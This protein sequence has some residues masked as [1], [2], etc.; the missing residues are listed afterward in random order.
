[1]LPE[2]FTDRMRRMLGDEYEEFIKAFEGERHQ[3]LRLNALKPGMGGKTGAEAPAGLEGN[4]SPGNE[5]VAAAEKE[6]VGLER[7]SPV[8]W[9]EN[10]YYYEPGLQPGK[11]PFHEAGVYYIQEPSAM[12][13][14]ELLEVKPG[15]R[16][17]DLCAAPGGKSTQM[18]AKL[19]G[20]GILVCNEI[21]PARAKILSE[22]VERMGIGNACVTNETPERLAAA[23]PEYFDRILVDAPCSGEGMFRKNPAACEEWSPENVRLCAVRQ[24]EILDCGAQMLRPGGRLVYS[25][26]TFAEEEDEGS[27]E[28]FLG[29]HPDFRLVPVESEKAGLENCSGQLAGTIRLM[30]HKVR[31]EGHFAAVL[32]RVCEDSGLRSC[33]GRREG[34]REGKCSGSL[35]Y[36]GFQRAP[37]KELGDYL[38][39]CRENLRQ[40][41]GAGLKEPGRREKAAERTG[42]CFDA[43][44]ERMHSDSGK[45]H[46]GCV[47]LGDHLYLMPE[48]MPDLKGL[49][50]LRAGLHLGELKKNRFEPSHALALTLAPEEAVH[51][52]NLGSEESGVFAYLR[53][54]AFPAA[55][56]KGWYLICVDGF[57]LGWGKLSGGIMKNHYPRGLR[58]N[59]QQEDACLSI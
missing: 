52:L 42:G 25:T 12:A 23:F 19:Q 10:C 54:E 27:V 14:G 18:A 31:G 21:H 39:F 8:P 48:D 28:R 36:G 16:V 51:V 4:V 47:R 13:P 20:Q 35:E 53:G 32:E 5:P 50:I 49:K 33:S 24:D 58:R 40:V 34:L 1:M 43:C 44:V 29:R 55:G 37:E 59:L 41:P 15:D 11:H 30:P 46:V 57:S 6:K 45:N 22:N 3:A 17:L 2:A 26:C 7:L 9:A 56:D 38:S